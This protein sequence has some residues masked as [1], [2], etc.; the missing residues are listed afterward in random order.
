M[1][2]TDADDNPVLID[3]A[4]KMHQITFD[5]KTMDQ[6]PHK[7][8]PDMSVE[9]PQSMRVRKLMQCDWEEHEKHCPEMKI[10]C[11]PKMAF[12][13]SDSFTSCNCLMKRKHMMFHL[14]RGETEDEMS[15]VEEKQGPITGRSISFN[16][17][18]YRCKNRLVECRL[19]CSQ[20]VEANSMARA[21]HE[22]KDCPYRYDF[23]PM[24]GAFCQTL[25]KAQH[26]STCNSRV[27]AGNAK[28]HGASLKRRRLRFS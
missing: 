25:K 15:Q 10:R 24:C 26:G 28:I 13:S 7:Y 14:S 4:V 1:L 18:P 27:L 21:R 12:R 22:L 6:S 3:K 17:H 9:T 19:R 5:D 2:P 23:C 11:E 8:D 20:L 16:Y